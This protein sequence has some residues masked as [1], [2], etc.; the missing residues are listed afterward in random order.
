MIE[1]RRS[2]EVVQLLRRQ[3]H[4]SGCHV[5]FD[6]ATD[7]EPGMGIIIGERA[8]GHSMAIVSALPGVRERCDR[9]LPGARSA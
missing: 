7:D 2:S 4:T 9:A 5:L 8:S 6:I 1:L 3:V